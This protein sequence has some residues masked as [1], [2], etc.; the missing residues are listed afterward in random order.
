MRLLNHPRHR[1]AVDQLDALCFLF[2][3]FNGLFYNP[4]QTRMLSCFFF[5]SQCLIWMCFSVWI[6]V[7][8]SIFS[9]LQVS[10][11]LS[12]GIGPLECT[13]GEFRCCGRRTGWRC[14]ATVK[15]EEDRDHP[16]SSEIFARHPTAILMSCHVRTGSSLNEPDALKDSPNCKINPGA[17]ASSADRSR[18]IL[19]KTHQRLL[20]PG[21]RTSLNPRRIH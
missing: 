14:D 5:L 1:L 17:T 12:L 3:I 6:L 15:R 13:Y 19:I 10:L 16:E 21:M 20:S 11:A 9:L 2:K 4:P 8:I 7:Q 18:S